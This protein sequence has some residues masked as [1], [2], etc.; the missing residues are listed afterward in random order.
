MQNYKKLIGPIS[1]ISLAYLMSR[2]FGFV[3]EIL[4]ANWT[5]ISNNPNI[6]TADDIIKFID[7]LLNWNYVT[8][9]YNNKTGETSHVFS[10]MQHYDFEDLF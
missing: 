5:G 8:L 6:K 9:S 10:M 4:L 1:I 2:I 7:S 3:R